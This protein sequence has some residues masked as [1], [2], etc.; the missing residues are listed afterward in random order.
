[1]S[2]LTGMPTVTAVA[3]GRHQSAGVAVGTKDDIPP[4]AGQLSALG[5]RTCH[6]WMAVA[7]THTTTVK[8][9]IDSLRM[10]PLDVERM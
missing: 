8:T 4:P 1:V 6:A 7:P 2:I 9:M 10:S 5:A 3:F